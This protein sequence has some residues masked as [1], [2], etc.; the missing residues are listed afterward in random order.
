MLVTCPSKNS[1]LT[2]GEILLSAV[3]STCQN[4]QAAKPVYF[5]AEQL[6]HLIAQGQ[7]RN[8][9]SVSV[10]ITCEHS[11]SLQFCHKHSYKAET[12]H[13]RSLTKSNS[14]FFK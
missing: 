8:E 2:S 13:T 3:D 6:W 12:S 4:L 11:Q 5:M 9:E 14:F 1:Y 10:S 7:V